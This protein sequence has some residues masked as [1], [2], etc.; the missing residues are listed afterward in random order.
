MSAPTADRKATGVFSPSRAQ[1]PQRTLRTDRWWLP[2]LWSNL[3]FAAFLIY[4][5]VRASWQSAYWVEDYH[6]LTPFYSPCISASCAPGSSHLGVWLPEFPPLV[7]LAIIT[8]TG[9]PT[10]MIAADALPAATM[11]RAATRLP[12]TGC[13]RPIP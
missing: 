12:A 7:P 1:I 10:S 9:Q 13:T 4:G 11:R 3:G 6:Y 5:L 2:T 8:L